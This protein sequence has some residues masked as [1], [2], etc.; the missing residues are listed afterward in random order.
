M[1]QIIIFNYKFNTIN[2]IQFIIEDNDLKQGKYIPRTKIPLI[3]ANEA[4]KKIENNRSA[5]IIFAW[6]MFDELSK[7]I[8]SNPN[9]NPN[10][11]ISPLPEPKVLEINYD[12]NK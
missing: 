2:N 9:L 6:N 12:T 10:V 4:I 8:M 5:C 11:L 1:L 7:K 3:S